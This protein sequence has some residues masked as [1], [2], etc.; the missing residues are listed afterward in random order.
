MNEFVLFR[1]AD[2]DNSLQFTH[3]FSSWNQAILKIS[4]VIHFNRIQF[5]LLVY[6]FFA[7]W[8]S[9]RVIIEWL[10]IFAKFSVLATF[11][12]LGKVNWL[13]YIFDIQKL[14]KILYIRLTCNIG[15]LSSE[16]AIR[17]KWLAPIFSVRKLTSCLKSVLGI[18][19]MSLY[20]KSSTSNC[21]SIKIELYLIQIN[22]L[23][24]MINKRIAVT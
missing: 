23:H 10:E 7:K 15:C 8:N 4:H 5:I 22:V 16:F 20:D 9:D 17:L 12:W 24:I 11:A 19:S 18:I 6:S 1:C 3:E 21:K 13:N 14:W 2:V